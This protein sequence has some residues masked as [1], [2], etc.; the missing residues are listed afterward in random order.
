MSWVTAVTMACSMSAS[1][2]STQVPGSQVKLR[3]HVQRDVVVAGEL[4]RAQHQHPAPGGRHLEHLLVA[5]PGEPA[6]LGD[7]PGVGA[8]H[9]GDVGV[10]LADVGVERGGQGHRGG[11]GSAPA[12]GG[13]VPFGRH[14]LEAGHHRDPPC[15]QGPAQPVGL[16]LEDL[17]PGVHGVGDDAR[18]GCR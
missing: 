9:P 18:P 13:D 8:E 1:S 15:S 4:H 12:E 5:D 3:A 7:D 6:G 11:V 14:A 17:G 16:D 2:S 10:D